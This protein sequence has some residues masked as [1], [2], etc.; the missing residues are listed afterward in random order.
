[1]RGAV[2]RTR[3]KPSTWAATRWWRTNPMLGRD[4]DRP[5][6]VPAHSDHSLHH[7]PAR[8][9]VGLTLHCAM[10]TNSSPRITN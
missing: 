7:G 1:M 2:M 6:Q 10:R 3:P 4:L 9:D 5:A 8:N